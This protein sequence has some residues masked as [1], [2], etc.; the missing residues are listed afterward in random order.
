MFRTTVSGALLVLLGATLP[1]HAT[2]IEWP[3]YD[4]G[5]GHYYELVAPAGGITWTAAK[6]AAEQRTWLATPG[7]LATVNSS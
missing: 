6:T 4:G 5:S 1:V 2:P 3:T 7:H